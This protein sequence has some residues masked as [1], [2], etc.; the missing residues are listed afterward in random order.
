VAIDFAG[1][2]RAPKLRS[3]SASTLDPT[4]PVK[5]AENGAEAFENVVSALDNARPVP[6]RARGR[7]QRDVM[8]CFGFASQ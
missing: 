4:E 7:G 2:A 6:G 5:V 3:P 1:A 8:D